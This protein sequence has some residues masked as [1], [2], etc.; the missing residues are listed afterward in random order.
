MDMYEHNTAPLGDIS[1]AAITQQQMGGIL[2][3]AFTQ[4]FMYDKDVSSQA[5]KL[6]ELAKQNHATIM[7]F[8]K[9][10]KDTDIKKEYDDIL[11]TYTLPGPRHWKKA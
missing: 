3:D 9:S 7:E 11:A 2:R 6:Q 4:K 10:I 8:G 1:I 5:G